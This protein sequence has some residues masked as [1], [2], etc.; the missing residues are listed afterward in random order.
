MSALGSVVLIS[1][2]NTSSEGKTCSAAGALGL[3]YGFSS[4]GLN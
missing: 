2:S 1:V 4:P 3:R